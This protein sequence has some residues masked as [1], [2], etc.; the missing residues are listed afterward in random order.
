MDLSVY[1]KKR[2][3]HIGKDSASHSFSLMMNT[4][5]PERNLKWMRGG[6]GA[7]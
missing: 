4:S 1:R 3:K 7:G 2:N 6:T 5:V